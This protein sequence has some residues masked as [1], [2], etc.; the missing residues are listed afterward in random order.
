MMQLH[1]EFKIKEGRKEQLQNAVEK[2]F[3][4][5]ISTQKGFKNCYFLLD[6]EDST[7]GELIIAFNSEEDRRAWVATPLHE[8]AWGEVG[9][10]LEVL[11]LK[12]YDLK[13]WK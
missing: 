6:R 7:K 11:V 2:I 1:V 12:K 8:T 9:A 4:P 3:L 10:N 5:A 13:A